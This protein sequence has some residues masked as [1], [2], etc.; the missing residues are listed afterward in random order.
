[1]NN[2]MY[3]KDL[4]SEFKLCTDWRY[5]PWGS[6][7]AVLFDVCAAIDLR[8]SDSQT[9]GFLDSVEYSAGLGGSH[10][11]DEMWSEIFEDAHTGDLIRFGC[12]LERY[13]AKLV[14]AGRDY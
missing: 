1:M 5:D 7:M 10:V 4:K 8:L 2:H 12:I 6:T 3:L 13:R 11:E 9:C 14:L